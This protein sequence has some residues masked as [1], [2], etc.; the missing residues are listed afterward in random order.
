MAVPARVYLYALLIISD[1]KRFM[2]SERPN[3]PLRVLTRWLQSNTAIVFP[4]WN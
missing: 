1:K 4:G 2:E 3:I